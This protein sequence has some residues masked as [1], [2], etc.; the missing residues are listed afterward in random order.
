MRAAIGD[1]PGEPLDFEAESDGL[2]HSVRQY[3]LAGLMYDAELPRADLVLVDVQGAETI[4]IER[5]RA[6]FDAGR[7]RFLVVSTHHHSISGDPLTHQNALRNLL[8][9]GAH[10]IAEHTVGESASGDG[11]IAV[12]FDPRDKDFTVPVSHGR[13]RDSLNRGFRTDRPEPAR[14]G[15]SPRRGTGWCR[16]SPGPWPARDR[17]C[18]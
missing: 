14:A 12:S 7:V 4:L 15:P 11:L 13:Y 6:V 10:V 2:T 17:R 3:D 1:R 8:D 16:R 18:R 9:A 5:A